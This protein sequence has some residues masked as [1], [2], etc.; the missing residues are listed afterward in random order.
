MDRIEN[1]A[2]DLFSTPNI[3]VSNI[4]YLHSNFSDNNVY[5]HF[6]V[7]HMDPEGSEVPV[8]FNSMDSMYFASKYKLMLPLFTNG[9]EQIR[10]RRLVA[11]ILGD[12]VHTNFRTRLACIKT[13]KGDKYYG[14]PGLILDRNFDPILVLTIKYR[15]APDNSTECLGCVCHIN[16]S[17]FCNQ[18]R[19]IEK[20][21]YK[22]II[23]L[24]ATDNS[25][26]IAR[27]GSHIAYDSKITVVIDDCSQFIE[28]PVIP[29]P[30][31]T[32]DDSINN[33]IAGHLDE[34][35]P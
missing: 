18:D 34:L 7:A 24:Y 33:F 15:K 23:P 1:F 19:L 9:E 22:K 30:T 12:F 2:F 11:T 27:M 14:A 31:N 21:I 6:L 32:S 17:I 4:E 13:N 25:P 3:R 28:K 29:T 35:C 10:I 16:K 20:A 5:Q 26:I 8:I